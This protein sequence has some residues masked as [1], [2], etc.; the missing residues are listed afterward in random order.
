M[1][2]SSPVPPSL[3]EP[4]RTPPPSYRRPQSGHLARQMA[5]MSRA[6]P[7]YHSAMAMTLR[8][9]EALD[10]AA[11]EL[12]ARQHR[13]L[14]DLVVNAVDE[15]IRRHDT[16]LEHTTDLEVERIAAEGARRYAEA[17]DRLGKS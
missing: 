4:H 8:L 6:R 16:N 7:N 3:T 12:A 11:G 5:E 14:H 17:L 13:S 15:Y 2:G 10:V 1:A 9:P